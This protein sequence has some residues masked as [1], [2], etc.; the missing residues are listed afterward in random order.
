MSRIQM[1]NFRIDIVINKNTK[2]VGN[3]KLQKI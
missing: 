2:K 1:C 3:K